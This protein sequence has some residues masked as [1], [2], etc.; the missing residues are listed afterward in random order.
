V[1]L[2]LNVDLSNLQHLW[3][4]ELGHNN[5]MEFPVSV[6]EVPG[7]LQLNLFGITSHPRAHPHHLALRPAVQLI[8]HL[9]LVFSFASSTGN[10]LSVV[11]DDIGRLTKLQRLYLSCNKIEHLPEQMKGRW[12]HSFLLTP[13]PTRTHH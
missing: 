11:P 4:L 5:L 10:G 9:F 6:F 3:C 8:H 13:A 12:S 7:L 2:E 1:R